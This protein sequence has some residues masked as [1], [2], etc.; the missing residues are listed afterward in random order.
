MPDP[1]Q[2][3]VAVLEPEAPAVEQAAEGTE[4]APPEVDWPVEGPR[5][6]AE[7]EAATKALADLEQ[8]AK[9]A[10]GRLKAASYPDAI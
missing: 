10:E 2:A 9:S 3:G 4:T 1:E 6:K 5:L 7:A 8:R